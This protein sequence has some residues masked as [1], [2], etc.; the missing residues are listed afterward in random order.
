VIKT[1]APSLVLVVCALLLSTGVSPSTIAVPFVLMLAVA[2]AVYAHEV[3][4]QIRG[5]RRSGRDRRRCP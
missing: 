4:V 3:K 2:L 5:E 1:Y